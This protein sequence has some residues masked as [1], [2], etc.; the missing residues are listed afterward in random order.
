MKRIL[1]ALWFALTAPLLTTMA[2]AADDDYPK[3]L[4]LPAGELSI[5]R[6]QPEELSGTTLKSRA[7]VAFTPSGATAKEFGAAWFA[8]ELDSDR[9]ERLATVRKIT[10]TNLKFADATALDADAIKNAFNARVA[11][12]AFKISLE[13]LTAALRAAADD[14]NIR[15]DPPKIFVRRAPAMLVVVD[16]DPQYSPV[17]N[18][19]VLQLVNSPFGIFLL[20][21]KYYLAGGTSWFVAAALTGK[22]SALAAEKVP[23]A[24]VAAAADNVVM[25]EENIASAPEIIVSTEPAELIEID[26]ATR[27]SPLNGNL[28]KVTNSENTVY[29]D[30]GG[31]K[32]FVL[33]SGRWFANKE[34][35]EKNWTYVEA[36]AL[37]ADFRNIPASDENFAARAA[38]AGTDEAVEAAMDAQIPHTTKILLKDAPA[39][40]VEY[41]GEPQFATVDNSAVRYV[42]NASQPVF[43]YQNRYYAC[44]NGAWYSGATPH[45]WTVCTVVPGALYQLPPSHP[46]YYTRYVYV[47]ERSPEY[48]IVG[49][50]PGY[51]GSFYYRGVIVYGTGYYYRPWY[52]HRYFPRPYTFGFRAAYHSSSADWFFAIGWRSSSGFFAVNFRRD[53]YAGNWW[54]PQ[55]Y[56]DRNLNFFADARRNVYDDARARRDR[57]APR[58]VLRPR[59]AP[60]VARHNERAAPATR[61][62][63]RESIMTD[64]NGNVYRR[65]ENNQWQQRQNNGW[66]NRAPQSRST[67]PTT[68]R[69]APPAKNSG[70]SAVS[71]D[72]RQAPPA[73]NS[74]QSAVSR[75]TR[76]APPARQPAAPIT[77]PVKRQVPPATRQAE[78]ATPITSPVKRQAPPAT[79]Q[80]EPAAPITQSVKRQAPPATRQAEPAAPITQSVK[81]QAPPATRRAEP[82]API[83]SP[84]KRQAPP[85]TRQAEPAAPERQPKAARSR[86]ENVEDEAAAQ[87]R[88]NKRAENFK[89]DRGGRN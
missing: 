83:T 61:D 64:R 4:S 2:K 87:D 40:T 80:A 31:G 1:L 41:D 54:G 65:D 72:T 43:Y 84:V 86:A 89:R 38:V 36:D 48:V 16:G 88:S 24:I 58:P 10:M 67:T 81:R 51:T 25:P 44:V 20:D 26:G 63:A 77:S 6:P 50:T 53:A 5:Y 15:H 85:A 74:G 68:T 3:Q 47:Y 73:K 37:P 7:A 52:R 11:P 14:E 66:V 23:A 22:W 18:S 70:Q 35:S 32:Y 60:V 12:S 45:L 62:N 8:A 75:D 59:P 78:P 28:M 46:Y 21:K 55:R 69:Q 13:D 82:A 17:E 33:L 42:V 9:D 57:P 34:L 49:Y 56:R 71:R 30:A 39:V 29:Y 76:Q 19:A 27:M 79:R